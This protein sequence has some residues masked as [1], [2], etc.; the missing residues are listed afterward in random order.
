MKELRKQKKVNDRKKMKGMK[1]EERGKVER[2]K[3]G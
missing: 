2:S 1:D 3:T